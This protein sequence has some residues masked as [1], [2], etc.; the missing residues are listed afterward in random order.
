[1][2]HTRHSLLSNDKVRFDR[3]YSLT[4][5][6][7]LLLLDLQD[8]VPV[9]L[10]CDLNV[11]LRLALLVLQGA[12][13][14]DD[15]GVLNAPAHLRVCDILVQHQTVEDLAVLDLATRDL[16]DSGISLDVDL[17][18]AIPGLPCHCSHSLERKINH[19]V[20]PSRNK[21]GADGGRDKLVHGLVIIDIDRHRDFVNDSKGIF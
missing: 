18:L 16:L 19:L 14:E 7:N 3:Q 2:R 20:H 9:I 10:L 1:M 4:H 12:I 15:S 6:L 21:L 13:Q 5:R 11:C 8:T 17:S